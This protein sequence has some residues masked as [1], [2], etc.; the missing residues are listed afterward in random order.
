MRGRFPHVHLLCTSGTCWSPT[1]C[2]GQ[3]GCLTHSQRHRWM[4]SSLQPAVYRLGH[5]V[6]INHSGKKW[7]RDFHS[8]IQ[9]SLKPN[10]FFSG[11]RFHPCLWNLQIISCWRLV[12]GLDVACCTNYSGS[13]IALFYSPRGLKAFYATWLIHLFIFRSNSR[14]SILPKDTGMQTESPNFWLVY[15]LQYLLSHSHPTVHWMNL[16]R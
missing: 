10:F 16:C 14:F 15:R 6:L 2:G 4:V 1:S 9:P 5:A 3:T 12:S 13:Y 8:G 7:I 11:T